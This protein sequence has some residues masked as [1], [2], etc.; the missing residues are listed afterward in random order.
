M[1]GQL[2]VTR[3]S[4]ICPVRVRASL[5]RDLCVS[6]LQN[7][8]RN[9]QSP[10]AACYRALLRNLSPIV[11]LNQDA[12]S[13]LKAAAVCALRA[14]SCRAYLTHALVFRGCGQIAL[15]N[16]YWIFNDSALVQS[17]AVALCVWTPAECSSGPFYVRIAMRSGSSRCAR[18]LITRS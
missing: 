5:R 16:G 11:G 8:L 1:L 3:L 2:K 7:D 4:E 15:S 9:C 6:D 14:N 12:N 18:S 17:G 10:P 13:S